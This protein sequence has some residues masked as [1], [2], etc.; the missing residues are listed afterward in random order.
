MLLHRSLSEFYTICDLLDDPV[1]LQ[2]LPAGLEPPSFQ[3]L[4]CG[5]QCEHLLPL[6]LE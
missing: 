4:D 1:V 6:R 2:L 3:I 5:F